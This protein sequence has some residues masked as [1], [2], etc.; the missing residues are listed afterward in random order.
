MEIIQLTPSQVAEKYLELGLSADKVEKSQ[1]TPVGDIPT[2]GKFAEIIVREFEDEK[3]AKHLYPLLTVVSETGVKTGEIPVASILRQACVV[4]NGKLVTFK[5]ESKTSL[6]RG[7]FGLKSQRLN[8]GFIFGSET[9]VV[10]ELLGKTFT[11]EIVKDLKVPVIKAG[12]EH[13]KATAQEAAKIFEVKPKSPRFL[14][15]G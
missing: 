13:F 11:M 9:E 5:I 4:E 10:S 6:N 7:K 1:K 3:G 12:G 14:T 15:L 8:A 2:G